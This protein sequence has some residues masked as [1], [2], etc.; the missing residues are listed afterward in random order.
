MPE[1][2]QPRAGFPLDNPT[3]A[4]REGNKQKN[5]PNKVVKHNA[6]SVCHIKAKHGNF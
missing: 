6:V 1:S 4:F 5:C 3:F 2:R